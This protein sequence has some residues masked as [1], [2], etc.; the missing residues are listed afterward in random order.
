MLAAQ[1]GGSA[2]FGTAKHRA[3][4]VGMVPARQ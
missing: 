1:C 2:F 4:I 3:D